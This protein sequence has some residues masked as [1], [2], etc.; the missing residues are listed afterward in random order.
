MPMRSTSIGLLSTA[1]TSVASYRSIRSIVLLSPVSVATSRSSMNPGFSPAAWKRDPPVRHAS[2]NAVW[3]SVPYVGRWLYDVVVMTL[4]PAASSR[5][6]SS[7]LVSTASA[8]LAACT[9]TSGR[10]ARISSLSVVART[11][12]VGGRPHSAPASWPA[13]AGSYTSTPTS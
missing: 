5:Q 13:L 12:V 11:P 6:M 4:M 9:T 3:V 7:A 2:M 1:D 8:L 10:S